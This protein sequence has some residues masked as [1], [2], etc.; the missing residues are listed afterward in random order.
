[1][2]TAAPHAPAPHTPASHAR[3]T[4]RLAPALLDALLDEHGRVTRPRLDRLWRYYRNPSLHDPAATVPGG[5]AALAQAAGLPDRLRAPSAD[6]AGRELVIENDIAWRVH[7]LVDF[8]VGKAVGIRSLA[9]DPAT[10][11]AVDALLRDVVTRAGGPGFFQELALLGAVYGHVDLLVHVHA[12]AP[13]PAPV[14]GSGSGGDAPV[15]VGEAARIAID[16]V[17]PTRG[18]PLTAG[19]DYRRLD[20]YAVHALRATH[21]VE[22]PPLLSRVG[23]RVTGRSAAPR[24]AVEHRT[25]VWTAETVEHFVADG[26]TRPRRR[27]AAGPNPLGRVPVVHIQNLPQPFRYAGLSD[28]EPLIPLQDELNTRLSDRA[29]RLTFQAFKMYLG[30]G[31]EHFTD[32]PVG[33]GQ[34]WETHNVDAEIQEFGGD[35]AAPSEEAHINEVR[36][37]MDKASGVTPVAAGI[38]GGKVGNLTSENALRVTLLGLLAKTQK[39]RLTYGAGLERLCEQVLHAADVL[40]VLHTDPADRRVRLDW[41]N[42]IPQGEAE[43][44]RVALQKVELGVPRARVLAELGYAPDELETPHK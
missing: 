3:A 44:L 25:T 40:G 33:P 19:D 20:A 17:T 1:M 10:A 27:V 12:H 6:A 34:M 2:P 38:I 18:V 31:I 41:P 16:V 39:K 22:P 15:D 42:P 36:Q 35:A 4:P 24:R 7:A 30:K 37:A 43:Q 26:P 21:A 32:R 5:A 9:G 14:P 29:N 23:R 8:M 28:V 11:A 13:T